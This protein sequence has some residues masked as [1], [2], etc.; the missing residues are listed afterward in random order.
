[1]PDHGVP[2]A[3][4]DRQANGRGGVR[5]G[6]L[7]IGMGHTEMDD[8]DARGRAATATS[9]GGEL[10]GGAQTAP[11]GKHRQAASAAGGLGR[12]AG[13]ALAAASSEDRAA[14]A[15]AHANPEAVR[16]GAATVVRLVGA[17][18]GAGSKDL[19]WEGPG[20]PDSPPMLR[21]QARFGQ[22]RG[23][24]RLADRA[25]RPDR[26]GS[27][28]SCRRPAVVQV[29]IRPTGLCPGPVAD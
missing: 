12:E 20:Q 25:D 8:E 13:A 15:R 27:W 24:G 26:P 1:M 5:R 28:V 14:R 19:R 7:R 2:H 11:A 16:L 21:A 9:G 18:H 3:A 6:A 22:T 10:G 29:H 4:S 23:R 17:L